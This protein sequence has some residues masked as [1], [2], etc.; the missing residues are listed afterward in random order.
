[1]LSGPCLFGAGLHCFAHYNSGIPL[2][3]VFVEIA[4]F[5]CALLTMTVLEIARHGFAGLAMA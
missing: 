2:R 5:I 4:A 1:M 3:V